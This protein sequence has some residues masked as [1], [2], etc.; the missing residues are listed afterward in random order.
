M[1]KVN[2]C[3]YDLHI[4]YATLAR[5]RPAYTRRVGIVVWNNR[6][7]A[8]QTLTTDYRKVTSLAIS[9]RIDTL[10]SVP[11]RSISTIDYYVR[12]KNRR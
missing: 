11:S 4:M 12:R 8:N 3:L 7:G 9:A 10:R 6:A 1:H 2:A 5:E